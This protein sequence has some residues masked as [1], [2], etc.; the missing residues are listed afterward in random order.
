MS[1]KRI[2][3]DVP[4]RGASG[5]DRPGHQLPASG[6]FQRETGEALCSH[7]GSDGYPLPYPTQILFYLPGEVF[8]ISGFRVV[9]IHA[10]SIQDYIN[11]AS[12]LAPEGRDS[13]K[14]AK[15]FISPLYWIRKYV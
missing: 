2:S 15:S 1:Q 9:T 12:F 4:G 3:E 11:D 14:M 6:R 8:K 5:G 7:P 13:P 10:V